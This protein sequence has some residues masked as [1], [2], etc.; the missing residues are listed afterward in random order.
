ML[1]AGRKKASS[2]KERNHRSEKR[3]SFADIG[4]ALE[5]GRRAH[6]KRAPA[7]MWLGIRDLKFEI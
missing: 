3:L 1:G 7:G 6:G 2:I 4:V 5:D